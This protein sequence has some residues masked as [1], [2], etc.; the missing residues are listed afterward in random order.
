MVHFSDETLEFPPFLRSATS[1]R[2]RCHP[3]ATF[4]ACGEHGHS[5]PIDARRLRTPIPCDIGR[6]PTAWQTSG[7]GAT[8][9]MHSRQPSK[10]ALSQQPRPNATRASLLEQYPEESFPSFSKITII[11]LQNSTF[12]PTK[13]V[14]FA[15]NHLFIQITIAAMYTLS[16]IRCN[17]LIP[18]AYLSNPPN[19]IS[20]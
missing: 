20:C 2:P 5:T 1:V 17:H 6:R 12:L 3:G 18:I 16:Y 14:K 9:H 8:C 7:G 15:K 13:Y 10:R 4:G 11:L 19:E